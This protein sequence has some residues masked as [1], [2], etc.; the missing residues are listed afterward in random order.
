MC[1]PQDH[2]SDELRAARHAE[3]SEQPR[4]YGRFELPND[5][6]LA[7]TFGRLQQHAPAGPVGV[8]FTRAHEHLE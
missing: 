3:L 7:V 1:S 8:T 6:H 4:R 2:R 5:A